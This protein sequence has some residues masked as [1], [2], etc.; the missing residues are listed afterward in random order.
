[1]PTKHLSIGVV[2]TIFKRSFVMAI[3]GLIGVTIA[4]STA[5]HADTA[6]G[7]SA[8]IT[9]FSV[10]LSLLAALAGSAIGQRRAAA[11]ARN[12]IESSEPTH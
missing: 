5:Q 2:I 10:V 6:P 4:F 12:E 11:R 7:A 1:M 3:D 8:R 9:F